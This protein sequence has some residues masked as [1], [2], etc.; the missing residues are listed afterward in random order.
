[1]PPLLVYWGE[2]ALDAIISG[3]HMLRVT[4][5]QTD[6]SEDAGL[7]SRK[8]AVSPLWSFLAEATASLIAK[9]AEDAMKNGGSPTALGKDS[10][11]FGRGKSYWLGR[12]SEGRGWQRTRKVG[13]RLSLLIKMLDPAAGDI[14]STT[15]HADRDGEGG[16]DVVKNEDGPSVYGLVISRRVVHCCGHVRSN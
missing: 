11:R 16:Q 7:L 13:T 14:H 10:T 1:M 8:C 15:R 5:H 6:L 2:L 4:A 3:I 12:S 9:N